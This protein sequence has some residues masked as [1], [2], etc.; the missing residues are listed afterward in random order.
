MNAQ[1]DQAEVLIL[2]FNKDSAVETAERAR[3]IA[4]RSDDSIW[5]LMIVESVGE[6]L[7][8]IYRRQPMALLVCVEMEHLDPAAELI[9]A[10]R[11][12][13]PHLPLLAVSLEHN[14]AIERAVRVAGATHYH[15]LEGASDI[16]LLEETLA[17]IGLA[18]H[19]VQQI[20]RPP[21]HSGASPPRHRARGRP[22]RFTAR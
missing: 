10:L 6:V 20:E 9:D 22:R 16:H 18:Q 1:S 3:A 7:R 14:S 12:R 2:A 4:G 11:R 15:P 17:S 19:D 21:P 5:P 8:T 13:R